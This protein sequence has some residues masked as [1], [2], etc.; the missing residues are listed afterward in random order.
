MRA[1][2]NNVYY[3][4]VNLTLLIFRGECCLKQFVRLGWVRLP[5]GVCKTRLTTVVSYEYHVLV[6]TT[7]NDS[8]QG[9]RDMT[10]SMCLELII[11]I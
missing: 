10:A 1:V 2:F 4:L 7:N 11:C 6:I 8:L 3:A 9:R 5:Q